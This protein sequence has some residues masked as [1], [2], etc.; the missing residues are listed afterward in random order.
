MTSTLGDQFG[1]LGRKLVKDGFDNFYR[2]FI[3]TKRPRSPPKGSEQKGNPPQNNLIFRLRV[4]TLSPITY[5]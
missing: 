2:Q 5:L 4:Y 1:S 3:A